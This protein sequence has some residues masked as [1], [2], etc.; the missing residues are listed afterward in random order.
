MLA[1]AAVVSRPLLAEWAALDELGALSSADVESSVLL[2]DSTVKLIFLDVTAYTVVAVV[3]CFFLVQLQSA[4]CAALDDISLFVV[5]E[6]AVVDVPVVGL[7]L[8]THGVC[9]VDVFEVLAED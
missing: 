7:V 4:C 3:E 6:I 2:R 5:V 8:K 1:G 9:V